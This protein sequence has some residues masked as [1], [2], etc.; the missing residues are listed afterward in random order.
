M[1]RAVRQGLAAKGIGPSLVRGRAVLPGR[2]HW[3]EGLGWCGREFRSLGI[4]E[5]SA[6]TWASYRVYFSE[7]LAEP[8]PA[9]VAERQ[10]RRSQKPL[11]ATP[12]GFESLRRHR[13]TRPKLVAQPSPA[14]S[15]DTRLGATP[16]VPGP[17]VRPLSWSAHSEPAG[18][19]RDRT[20]RSAERERRCVLGRSPA[21]AGVDESVP[22]GPR[23]S[24][25]LGAQARGVFRV[26]HVRFGSVDG[27]LRS[28][29]PVARQRHDDVASSLFLSLSSERQQDTGVTLVPGCVHGCSLRVLRASDRRDQLLTGRVPVSRW[30][31][32]RA[33]SK[34]A[35]P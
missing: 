24:S 14:P 1:S 17:R 12:C 13:V 15:P 8:L 35:N 21:T 7:A 30:I 3:C 19:T 10:T 34:K 26:Q 22:A 5:R 18:G 4:R 6:A 11:G 20:T 32:R 29:S 23:F 28:S 33:T 2:G 31:A 9:G 25:P 27:Q 16:G